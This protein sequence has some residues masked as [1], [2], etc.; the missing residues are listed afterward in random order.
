VK[1]FKI[2]CMQ[3]KCMNFRLPLPPRHLDDHIAVDGV[4]HRIN[5]R[6][7]GHATTEDDEA[8][9]IFFAIL[10]KFWKQKFRP[11]FRSNYYLNLFSKL[12]GGDRARR[13]GNAGQG[14]TIDNIESGL[15]L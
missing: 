15:E 3:L 14:V 5:P 10:S 1:V 11:Y 12:F 9:I 13:S 6:K 2:K 7:T 8:G 4:V